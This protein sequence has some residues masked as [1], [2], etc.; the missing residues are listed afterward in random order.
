MDHIAF[1]DLDGVV[2]NNEARFARAT[3]N[4]KIDWQIAFD[5]GLIVLDTL[6]DGVFHQ[7]NFLEQRGYTIFY[8]TSRPESMRDATESWLE[9]HNLQAARTLVMKSVAFQFTKT[10]VWKAGMVDTLTQM[11]QCREIIIID[12]EQANIDE[13]KKFV[14]AHLS[15]DSFVSLID[16]SK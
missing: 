14:H 3:S 16:A 13:I 10:V 15:V 6:I 4:N 11:Y 12:D 8:L 1:V 9:E 2:A 7:L 5:P